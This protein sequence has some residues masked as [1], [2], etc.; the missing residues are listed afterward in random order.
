MKGKLSEKE[1]SL[2]NY[3]FRNCTFGMYADIFWN[4]EEKDKK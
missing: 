3:V 4:P 2:V 1:N